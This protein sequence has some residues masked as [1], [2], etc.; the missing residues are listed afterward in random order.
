MEKIFR[1]LG[2]RSIA[3]TLAFLTVISGVLPMVLPAANAADEP[4]CILEPHTH[5]E[6]CFELICTAAEDTLFGGHAHSDGCFAEKL[7]C[8]CEEG[9]EH[10]EEC[11]AAEKVCTLEEGENILLS[12]HAHGDGCFALTCTKPEHA[13]SEECNTPSVIE[14]IGDEIKNLAAEVESGK[15]SVTGVWDTAESK[16]D[17]EHI[18]FDSSETATIDHDDAY[19]S[20]EVTVI[21]SAEYP[22]D[23]SDRKLTITLAP[24]LEWVSN[25][26]SG[27]PTIMLDSVSSQQNRTTVYGQQLNNG[28]YTYTFKEGV[29]SVGVMIRVR[30]NNATNFD[31]V[32]D[33]ITATASCTENGSTV[34]DSTSLSTL[35]CEQFSHISSGASARS[36]IAKAETPVYQYGIYIYSYDSTSKKSISR[37]YDFAE[38]TVTAPKDVTLHSTDVAYQGGSVSDTVISKGWQVI[39]TDD[40]QDDVTVYT[41]RSEGFYTLTVGSS[42]EWV[43]PESMAGSNVVISYSNLKWKLYGDDEIHSIKNNP[44]CKTTFEVVPSKAINEIVESRSGTFT[45]AYDANSPDANY[46]LASFGIRNRGADPSA[47]KIVEYTF[48]DENIGVTNV[49]I[50]VVGKNTISV[51]VW[52]K[53]HGDDTWYSKTITKA[54]ASAS[55]DSKLGKFFVSNIDL[56]LSADTYLSALKYEMDYVDN[57]GTPADTSDDTRYGVPTQVETAGYTSTSTAYSSI[58][59]VNL[60]LSAS[61]PTAV[62]YLRI[63]DKYESAD[64]KSV[65]A[66]LTT[67]FSAKPINYMLAAN[68]NKFTSHNNI[69]GDSFDVTVTLRAEATGSSSQAYTV[70]FT[71]YPIIYIRDETGEGISNIRLKNAKGVDIIE[72]YPNNIS[73]TLDH[74]ETVDHNE[75]GIYALVYKID[76]SGLADLPNIED[77]YAA[78]VGFWDSNATKST[79]D[80]TYTVATPSTYNDGMIPHKL[81]DAI[82]LSDPEMAAR[83]SRAA[84]DFIDPFDVDCDGITD[85]DPE[86]LRTRIA[87]THEYT[88]ASR[89]DIKIGAAAKKANNSGSYASWDGSENYIQIEPDV[90]YNVR[91]S[92]LNGSGVKTSSDVEKM[93]YIYIPIP[94]E[95]EQWGQAA[96]GIDADGK[97]TSAFTYSTYLSTAVENPNTEVFSISYGTVNTGIFSS[98][99]NFTMLGEKL[100]KSSTAWS[101]SFSKDTNC[102]RIAVKGMPPADAAEHFILPLVADPDDALNKEVNIFSSIYYEDITNMNGTH[103]S[104]WYGSDTLAMQIAVGEVYGRIWNDLN[105]NGIQDDGEPGIKGIDVTLKGESS[106]S[107]KTNTNGE[108]SFVNIQLGEYVALF[109]PDTKNYTLSA[110]DAGSSDNTDSDAALNGST[111]VISGIV[112]PTTDNL[113]KQTYTSENNDAGLVPF[114]EISYNMKGDIPDGVSTPDA[115]KI[116]A[117]KDFTAA[118]VTTAAGYSFEGW[119]TDSALTEKFTDGTALI[120]DTVLYGEWSINE[121]TIDFDSNGGSEV[122]DI[123]QD[124]NSD[125]TAPADPTR[126]GY[127]FAGWDKAIPAK[128]PAADMKITAKWTINQYTIDFNSNGGSEVADITQD[129]NSDITAPADPTREGYTFAGWNIEIPAKMPANN[130]TITAGWTINKHDVRYNIIGETP[131]KA[132]VPDDRTVDYGTVFSAA[133]PAAISGYTFDGWYSDAACTVKYADGGAIKADTDLYGKWTRNTLTVSGTKTW[134]ENGEGFERPDA[135]TIVLYRNG[136]EFDTC[137]IAKDASAAEQSYSFTGL[138]ETDEQGNPYTYTVGEELVPEEYVSVVS[139]Y[140]ITNTYNVDRFIITKEWDN[141]GSPSPIPDS[142]DI[143]LLRDGALFRTVT[144]TAADSWTKTVS[145]PRIS[146]QGH[147]FT[148]S[149]ETVSGYIT[150]Y[151]TPIAADTDNDRINDTIT[152][153]IRNVYDMPQISVSGSVAWS[154]VPAGMTEPDLTVNLMLGDEII[155]SVTLPAGT[156]EYSFDGLDRYA[157]DGSALAYTIA[158]EPVDSYDVVCA[159]PAVDADGNV[160]VDITAEGTFTY[161]TLTISNTVT[162]EDAPADALFTYTIILDSEVEYP[163]D[164]SYSGTIRNGDVITLKGGESITISDILVGV[165]FEVSQD[166]VENFTITPASGKIEGAIA[167]APTAAEFSN[168]FRLPPVGNLEITN[169]V[170]GNKADKTLKFPF[171]V[172]FADGGSYE[173]KIITADAAESDTPTTFALRAAP[174][175]IQSGDTIEL[176]HGEMAIIYGLPA[177]IDYIVSE[178]KTFGYKVTATCPSGSIAE[179]G[180]RAS[181]I[182]EK[183]AVVSAGSS[184]PDTGDAGTAEIVALCIMQT[185]LITMLFCVRSM[186]KSRREEA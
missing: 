106:Y 141:T 23:A 162:G 9:S 36:K 71:H 122:A 127:T 159:A 185:A 156:T 61:N 3:I 132:A 154:K 179:E 65:T 113:G 102:I 183:N 32:A 34:S 134:V 18:P 145:I 11:Y 93:T 70:G 146:S 165:K 86:I 147:S 7:I 25:G 96:S 31:T 116:S 136:S 130:M 51:P 67:K 160:T 81:I 44:T 131:A 114:I 143:K 15:I 99:D 19:N 60:K 124:Y 100:K 66:T 40:S 181:F 63:Y 1:I 105:G 30:K 88:I 176:A 97:A 76:T 166:A 167:S 64:P 142:I 115:A 161:G 57:N 172:E 126:T 72:K 157:A 27:I 144:L 180:S 133:M 54:V 90:V 22:K 2:K 164:G 20:E 125:I 79:L 173:Y 182:N 152:Y 129:Y 137:S 186:K 89:A 53:V 138:Y 48:D 111:A 80:L 41:V 171:R 178:T 169:K 104:G 119:F 39:A 42:F 94:K 174:E 50:A 184:V 14:E 26:A 37:L 135:V 108:Y 43:F 101:D 24:C 28:S 35:K 49:S 52:Y 128:M 46:A 103:F 55:S 121:Y 112:V 69:A 75:D 87:V 155:D 29:S 62:S 109:T 91:N 73:V 158:T 149:E 151:D 10:G 140:D 177:G 5:A 92:V 148:L 33:A 170:T 59:G 8:S 95:G 168:N 153:V 6:E 117:G 74:T 84:A 98:G 120:A 77:R 107:A 163:Y 175:T 12:G 139:G 4:D 78:A 38:M 85:N 150:T 47:P 17:A 45:M 118:K 13:H 16:A 123:T 68:S 83:T 82:F 21:I 58:A 56:G 110:K